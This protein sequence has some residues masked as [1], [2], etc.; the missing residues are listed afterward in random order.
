M[1]SATDWVIGRGLLGGALVRLSANP[2]QTTRIRW[3][4]PELSLLDLANG[5]D[6]LVARE[7]PWRI[8]WSAGAGVT[9]TPRPVLDTEVEVFARFLAR[10][11]DLPAE[12]LARGCVFLASSVGGV[13]AGNPVPPF[14]E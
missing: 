14:T 11:S 8:F 13:Y 3:A 2:V 5:L 6:E 10:L 9:A 12:T 4:D 7:G 1:M